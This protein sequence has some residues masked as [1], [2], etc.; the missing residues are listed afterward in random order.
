MY[1]CGMWQNYE[2]LNCVTHSTY[3]NEWL[4]CL[5]Q[6]LG[7]TSGTLLKASSPKICSLGIQP[8]AFIRSNQCPSTSCRPQWTCVRVSPRLLHRLLCTCAVVGVCMGKCVS[9]CSVV[10]TWIECV[11]SMNDVAEAL[12]CVKDELRRLVRAHYTTDTVGTS[13]G[14]IQLM[15]LSNSKHTELVL[16]SCAFAWTNRINK[17]SNLNFQIKTLFSSIVLFTLQCEPVCSVLV[18]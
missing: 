4:S 17:G 3:V 2:M 7:L 13:L 12:C 18:P 16:T 14:G 1:T 10:S 5:P 15:R 8:S 6:G 11:H 9:M